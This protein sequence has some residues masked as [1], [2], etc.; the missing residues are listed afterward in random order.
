MRREATS[1]MCRGYR[2]RQVRSTR[3]SQGTHFTVSEY[4]RAQFL[5]YSVVISRFSTLSRSVRLDLSVRHVT[6]TLLYLSWPFRSWFR[7][8]RLLVT[9]CKLLSAVNLTLLTLCSTTSKSSVFILTL[10]LGYSMWRFSLSTNDDNDAR[11]ASF[12]GLGGRS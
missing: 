8:V 12:S 7:N 10:R 3:A 5:T 4:V 2:V 1:R 6:E 9:Q 11:I